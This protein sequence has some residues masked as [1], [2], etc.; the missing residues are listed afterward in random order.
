VRPRQ[1]YPHLTLRLHNYVA[2]PFTQVTF[3]EAPKLQPP[4]FDQSRFIPWRFAQRGGKYPLA[5][6]SFN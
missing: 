2:L 3:Y 5:E 4:G 1:F 6:T